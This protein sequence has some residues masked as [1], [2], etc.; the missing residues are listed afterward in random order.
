MSRMDVG[1]GLA[2]SVRNDEDG[3]MWIAWLVIVLGA[4]GILYN[5]FFTEQP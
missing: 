2:L 4:L 3:P 5:V 1:R